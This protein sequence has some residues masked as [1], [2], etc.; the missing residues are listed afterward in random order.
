MAF[1]VVSCGLSPKQYRKLTLL[2]RESLIETLE[3][4]HKK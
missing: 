1:F 3:K 4:R 2:E